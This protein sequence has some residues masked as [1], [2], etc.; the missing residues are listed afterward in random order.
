MVKPPT[1]LTAMTPFPHVVEASAPLYEAASLMKEHRVRHI[2][3][4]RSH[5]IVGMIT[6]RDI[7]NAPR[8]GVPNSNGT[9]P[10]VD[11]H[12]RPD[13]LIVDIEDPIEEVLLAMAASHSDAAIV[14]RRDRLAG[15]FTTVDVCRAFGIYLRAA[16]PRPPNNNAA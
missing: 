8:P 3:V 2:P 9:C 15:V 4:T 14:T 7:M 6:D 10:L 12:F 11:A 1:L 5:R 13:A 16:F